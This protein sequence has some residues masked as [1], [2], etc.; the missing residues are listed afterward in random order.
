MNPLVQGLIDAV[1]TAMTVG[2]S[3]ATMTPRQMTVDSITQ[4]YS[5][6]IPVCVEAVKDDP[7]LLGYSPVP[8][9]DSSMQALIDNLKNAVI[10]ATEET[11]PEEKEALE[12]FFSFMV[13]THVNFI[14]Q[15]PGI[16]LPPDIGNPER[17]S[18]YV[19]AIVAATVLNMFP[20]GIPANLTDIATLTQYYTIPITTYVLYVRANPTVFA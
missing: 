20:S 6:I 10:V 16:F 7:A 5:T 11:D 1:V 12:Y 14:R 15:Y 8:G 19:N 4:Y 2:V 3:P 9:I 17:I 18:D 13:F